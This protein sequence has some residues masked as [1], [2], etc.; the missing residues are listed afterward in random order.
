MIT[1]I[2]FFNKFEVFFMGKMDN[3]FKKLEIDMIIV[4]TIDVFLFSLFTFDIMF[5]N[6]ISEDSRF[7]S[8]R[9]YH[10]EYCFDFF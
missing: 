3:L 5:C 2:Y 9:F 7:F 8:R 1:A 10:S 6:A 4:H